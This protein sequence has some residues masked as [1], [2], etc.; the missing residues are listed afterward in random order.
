MISDARFWA[1]ELSSDALRYLRENVALCHMENR[2]EIL[3][4]DVLYPLPLG[5]LDMIVSNP[6]YVRR[7]DIAGLPLQLAAEPIMALDGG[8]DGLCFYRAIGE[9]ANQ[10]L[11]PGGMLIFEVGYDQADEVAGLM[12][13]Y[14]FRNISYAEDLAH[15][16]RCVYGALK[17]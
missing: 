15:I 2:I 4:G 7:G 10:M 11:K 17:Q 3:Q 5:E 8:E 14:N 6:P 1:V 12:E 16:D 13:K 9:R